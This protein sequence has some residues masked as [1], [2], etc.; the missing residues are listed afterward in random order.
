M[1]PGD[2][3]VSRSGVLRR[4]T[5]RFEFER[6]GAHIADASARLKN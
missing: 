6:R 5:S 2:N 1:N 3:D 4:S